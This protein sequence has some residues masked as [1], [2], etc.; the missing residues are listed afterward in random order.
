VYCD[1]EVEPEEIVKIRAVGIKERSRV[2]IGGE[3]IEL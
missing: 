1:V 3:G 2:R